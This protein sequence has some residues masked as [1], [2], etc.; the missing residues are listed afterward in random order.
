[1][2]SDKKSG[3]SSLIGTDEGKE[4]AMKTPEVIKKT[5]PGMGLCIRNEPRSDRLGTFWYGWEIPF[6]LNGLN[7]I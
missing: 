6:G 2:V 3:K 4:M 5:I 7:K 1:M